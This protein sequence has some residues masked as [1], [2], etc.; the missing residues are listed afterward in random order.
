M[1]R[2][3]I[4]SFFYYKIDLKEIKGQNEKTKRE[5]CSTIKLF[6]KLGIVNIHD[7]II[8]KMQ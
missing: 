6:L 2:L 3:F 5:N 8:K 7:M 4:F 1:L